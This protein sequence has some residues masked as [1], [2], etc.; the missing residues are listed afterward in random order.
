M[1]LSLLDA[2]RQRVIWSVRP[3][4]KPTLAP[5]HFLPSIPH[6]YG[7]GWEHYAVTNPPQFY[8]VR[9]VLISTTY[10]IGLFSLLPMMW[11]LRRLRNRRRIAA[12]CCRQCGYDLRA[13]ADRCPECGTAINT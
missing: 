6:D 1:D 7:I 4:P 3:R 5:T 8:V 13:S 9:T 10:T 12:G 2:L 11:A